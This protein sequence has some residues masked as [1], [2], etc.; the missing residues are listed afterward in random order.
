[1]NT[2][3]VAVAVLALF[4]AGPASFLNA[5]DESKAATSGPVR[6]LR[7][8][9][10]IVFREVY[11]NVAKSIVVAQTPQLRGLVSSITLEAKPPCKCD[12]I[13]NAIFQGPAGVR[14]VSFCDH[15]FDMG[16][17]HYA[18]PKVFYEKFRKLGRGKGW[19]VVP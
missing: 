16:T 4:A 9:T 19:N 8:A 18:M 2:K 7:G 3:A 1:M 15:C 14:F 12:H 6:L 17:N 10:N 5:N 13:Y 11:G